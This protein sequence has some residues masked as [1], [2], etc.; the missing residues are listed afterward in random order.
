LTVSLLVIGKSR[1]SSLGG[2]DVIDMP[3]YRRNDIP[4]WTKKIF[5]ETRVKSDFLHQKYPPCRF[6]KKCV[7]F[8]KFVK[9]LKTK[10]ETM[11]SI[12]TQ[13]KSVF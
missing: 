5:I 8:V 1:L 9:I 2:Q 13:G 3:T 11:E 10:S 4:T 6:V 7:S 12:E